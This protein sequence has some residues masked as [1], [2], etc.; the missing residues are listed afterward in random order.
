VQGVASSNL[1]VPT[2]SKSQIHNL[3]SSILPGASRGHQT[4]V[5]AN[6]SIA[7]SKA[8]WRYCVTKAGAFDPGLERAVGT[9]TLL[10]HLVTVTLNGTHVV[11]VHSVPVEE[12]RP[13]DAF[14]VPARLSAPPTLD[15]SI[16]KNC[17]SVG[18]LAHIANQK[19]A[20]I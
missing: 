5:R 4:Y 6:D 14:H 18:A 12:P 8:D 13:V 7:Q 3:G 1:A 19:N 20:Q 15:K 11:R 10:G 17:R 2:K 16:E 9:V